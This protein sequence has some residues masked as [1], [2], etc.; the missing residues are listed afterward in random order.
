LRRSAQLTRL[1]RSIATEWKLVAKG[2]RVAD[3]RPEFQFVLDKLRRESDAVAEFPDILGAIDDDERASL[4]AP[5]TP[6]ADVGIR[7]PC[8]RY[9]SSHDAIW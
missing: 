2:D 8:W 3:K 9:F 6:K 4:V 5:V 1:V 7:T